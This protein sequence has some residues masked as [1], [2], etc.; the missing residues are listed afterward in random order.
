[1]KSKSGHVCDVHVYA[2]AYDTYDAHDAYDAY[3]YVYVISC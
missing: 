3:V 2:Y 1:M